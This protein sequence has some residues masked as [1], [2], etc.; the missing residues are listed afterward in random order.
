MTTGG[1]IKKIIWPKVIVVIIVVVVYTMARQMEI[2]HPIA[3]LFPLAVAFIIY[4]GALDD[5]EEL[6]EL[7]FPAFV[8]TGMV[9]KSNLSRISCALSILSPMWT[10]LGFSIRQFFED[11]ASDIH[12]S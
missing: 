9:L 5:F 4:I 6:G 7:N 12:P 10:D 1:L 11:K 2:S 3:I 8:R